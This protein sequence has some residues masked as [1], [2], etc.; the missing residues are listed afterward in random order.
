MARRANDTRLWC[1]WTHACLVATN[2]S[3]LCNPEATR[4][5]PFAQ[6][7][8]PRHQKCHQR[9][10]EWW[11]S[12][13]GIAIVT[14]LTPVNPG[15]CQHIPEMQSQRQWTSGFLSEWQWTHRLP[16]PM[17]MVHLDMFSSSMKTKK[18]DGPTNKSSCNQKSPRRNPLPDNVH[19]IFLSFFLGMCGRL[20]WQ[21]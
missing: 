8:H 7:L 15:S 17:A 4:K 10:P 12:A 2:A 6:N 19:Y 1:Q 5:Q 9:L 21:G 13:I 16:S 3:T 18:F 20:P 11:Q 14:H